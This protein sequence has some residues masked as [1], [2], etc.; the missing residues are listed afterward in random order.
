MLDKIIE[1]S[2]Y[3]MNNSKCV[4]IDYSVLDKYIE[5]IEISNIKHWLSHNPYNLFDLGVEGVINFMLLYDSINYCFWGN[6]KWS[7]DGKDGTDC[8][9][10]VLLGYVRKT[11][12]LDFT[13]V[14]FSEF[15]ELM[16]GNIEIPFLEE[17]YN[18]L[19]NVSRV[20]NEKMNGNF[21]KYIFNIYG[22]KELFNLII[23]NFSS[24]KDEREYDGEVIYFYK[25]AQL[26]V[27]DI[28]HIREMLEGIKVD[29]SH[30]VGCSDYKIPQIMRRLGICIYN[31]ELS[32]VVDSKEEVM[33]SSIYEVEIRS[34]MLVVIDYIKEKL[35]FDAID[36]NDYFFLECKKYKDLKPYHLCRNTN[37]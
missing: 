5:G 35:G 12:N 11:K 13:K 25:L 19:V 1:S 15:E 34:S 2:K 7:I 6:P 30:L 3:V 18:T 26:L 9:L 37:Y 24:F 4:K 28:L 17:R 16:S 10:Y 36:I 33:V 20:V 31:D 27:S 29:Y 8:L 23:S 14:S 22:D 21:Y 32:R